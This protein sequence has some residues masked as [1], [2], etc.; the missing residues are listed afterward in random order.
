MRTDSVK[1]EGKQ[2]WDCQ[3]V[4]SAHGR[5]MILILKR[6]QLAHLCVLEQWSVE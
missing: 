3:A 5:F 1:R 6:E 4:W 2:V